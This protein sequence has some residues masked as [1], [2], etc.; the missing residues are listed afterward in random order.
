MTL[1]IFCMKADGLNFNVLLISL[2]FVRKTD[3]VDGFSSSVDTFYIKVHVSY[4]NID[5]SNPIVCVYTL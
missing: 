3:K 2:N 5:I 1:A 4:S